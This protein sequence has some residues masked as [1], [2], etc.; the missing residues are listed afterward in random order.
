MT[1]YYMAVGDALGSAYVQSIESDDGG[2]VLYRD[3]E[4]E[5]TRLRAALAAAEAERERLR[6]AMQTIVQVDKTR[7]EHHEPRPDGALPRTDGGTC[8]LTPKEIARAALAT[9]D[10]PGPTPG[11]GGGK[12]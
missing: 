9:A 12:E 4:S 1:R 3:V 5:L 6:E 7:Y 8:W 10:R 11:A 2:W